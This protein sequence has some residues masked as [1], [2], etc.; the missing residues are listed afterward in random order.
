[1][2]AR[3]DAHDLLKT[4]FLSSSF[5]CNHS[6]DHTPIIACSDEISVL[7]MILSRG[8]FGLTAHD[9]SFKNRDLSKPDHS[10]AMALLHIY[11]TRLTPATLL[12]PTMTTK[13]HPRANLQICPVRPEIVFKRSW[14]VVQGGSDCCLR[15]ERHTTFFLY[16][17]KRQDTL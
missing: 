9:N 6:Y 3:K 7:L 14:P 4:V 16:D 5:S 2:S 12:P 17:T 10:V 8:P 13:S 1:M 11:S 15:A